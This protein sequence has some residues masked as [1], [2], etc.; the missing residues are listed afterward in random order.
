M[1]DVLAAAKAAGRDPSEAHGG[2]VS[3][4]SVDDDTKR[5]RADDK[6]N[7]LLK[8]VLRR[9]DPIETRQTRIAS[10]PG[11]RAAA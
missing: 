8:V 4:L 1:S 7:G 10:P 2:H 3:T 11:G 6:L 5:E 9:V